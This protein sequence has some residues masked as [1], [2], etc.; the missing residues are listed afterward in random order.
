MLGLAAKV[1]G[2]CRIIEAD[3]AIETHDDALY[4]PAQG[5]FNALE[6]RGVFDAGGD[7]IRAGAY[8]RGV[9]KVPIN[10]ALTA[11]VD[12]R[13][14]AMAPAPAYLYGGPL[15]DHYGH[16][17]TA[18]LARLWPFIRDD[19]IDLPILMHAETDIDVLFSRSYIASI[20][21]SLN[22]DRSRFVRF[23][24]PTIV[25]R[26]IVPAPAFEEQKVGHR[27][28]G[29]MC[30]AIGADVAS[31]P[32]QTD[33]PAYLSKHKTV[34]GALRIGNET[35]MFPLLEA[36]GIDIVCPE[37]LPW[38]EQ[39]DLFAS[40]RFVVGMGSPLHTAIF[41]PPIGWTVGL[42][43]N[44]LVNTNML[45]MDRFR[46][47]AVVHVTPDEGGCMTRSRRNLSRLQV[48]ERDPELLAE[49]GRTPDTPD[50]DASAWITYQIN[51]AGRFAGDLI[52]FLHMN[53]ADV[54]LVRPGGARN[55]SGG[56]A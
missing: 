53:G 27:V 37:Q 20:L 8:Y 24:E 35:E 55:P 15:L 6:P 32:A 5:G 18:S 41:T 33:R 56:L 42:A 52:Q 36:A 23:S 10:Y 12:R 9:R 44:R 31:H 50:F 54:R 25:R 21:G 13:D 22:L 16:F 14:A 3:P 29:E 46:G 39:V 45:L 11:P 49:L 30:R 26:L 51:D 7:L 43:P 2:N 48:G 38:P 4:A 28:Y 19:T 34:G 17:L 1:W 47:G 40:R